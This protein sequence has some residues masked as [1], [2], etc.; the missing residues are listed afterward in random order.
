MHIKHVLR[1]RQSNFNYFTQGPQGAQYTRIKQFKSFQL[2]F[3]EMATLL[4]PYFKRPQ[5]HF[6][7]NHSF[8]TY[9]KLKLFD[10][11]YWYQ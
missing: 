3:L 7:V 9:V 8:E 2:H 6:G 5:L 11:T 4:P 1:I 10:D